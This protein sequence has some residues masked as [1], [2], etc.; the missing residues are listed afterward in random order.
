ML[1][2]CAASD[3]SQVQPSLLTTDMEAYY[4]QKKHALFAHLQKSYV[5]SQC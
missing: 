4:L 1:E 5:F 2:T 3:G